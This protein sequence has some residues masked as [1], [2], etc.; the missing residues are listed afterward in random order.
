M[1]LKNTFPLSPI[2]I[3]VLFCTL[4]LILWVVNPLC[5]Q[6]NPDEK[7]AIQFY[8]NG[9]YEKAKELFQ[10]I[11][12]KKQDT[13]IY[14][15]YYR[16]LLELQEYKD[17]ERVVKKQ[18]KAYPTLQ[19]YK[20][21]LGYVYEISGK[22]KDAYEVYDEAI[23]KVPNTENAYRELYNAFLAFGKRDYAEIVLMKARKQLQNNKL[24]SRELTMIYQQLNL[25]DKIFNEALNLIQDDDVT[26][27]VPAQEILQNL[28]IDDPDNQKHLTI[29]NGLKKAIQ[30]NPNNSCY[31][32]LYYWIC[33]LNKDFSEGLQ[34]AKAI[35]RRSK[36]SGDILLDFALIAKEN[37]AYDMAIDAL[38]A[39]IERKLDLPIS[40][41]AQFELLNVKYLRLT[42]IS[43]VKLQD[44]QALELEFKK[45]IDE[46]GIHSGTSDWIRKYAHLMAFYSNKPDEA[47]T[48][49]NKAITNAEND[50]RVIATYK[51][52][53]ADIL[54]HTNQIWDATLLYSQVDKDFPNDTIGQMAK[55]KNA[56]LSFYI[57]EFA[58]AQSQLDV[59]RAATSKLISN[60]AMYLSF[61]IS[62]NQEDEEESDEEDTLN[63]L[64][65]DNTTHNIALRMFAKADFLIF[66][67]NDNEALKYLDSITIYSPLSPLTDDVLY[68]RAQIAT[69]QNNYFVAE[70]YYKKIVESYSTDILGD[71]ALFKLAELYEYYLK[72][73]PEAMTCYQKLLKE[74][75]G[76][77]Y[78]VDARKRFRYLRGD[79]LE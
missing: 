31:L 72:N 67:N 61:I 13:Y 51:I 38:N 60:D 63:T 39:I 46:Y 68:T 25:T 56:K 24:F 21:D 43:P 66:Q 28:L 16:T 74:Y 44:A 55:F 76:S 32:K 53:L 42:S 62:D 70:K 54:L 35:D 59:L 3:C 5:A 41:S 12:D 22:N 15:Y 58:W 52:D 19:R 6:N 1:S 7:L 69:R 78:I 27:L 57:G 79:N 71:D 8:Q 10:K 30:N 36:N 2:R 9:E 73:I 4:F 75:P 64:F 47:S 14:F 11:Y 34:I 33:I 20:I 50:K 26:Y 49:L 37:R 48:I 65:N 17:L 23:K 77:L 40:T 18:Q 29:K 45:M